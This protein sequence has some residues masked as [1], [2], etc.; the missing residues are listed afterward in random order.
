M[1]NLILVD[2][3]GFLF[4]SFFAL[5]PLS[6]SK[7]QPSGA[8]SGFVQL[9]NQLFNE[10]PQESIIFALEG[11][12]ENFRKNIDPN[13]KA[14][15]AAT[16]P[17]LAA[18]VPVAI[19]WIEKM[20]LQS[21]SYDGFEA[22]DIIATLATKAALRGISVRII[23]HDKDLNQLICSE[24]SSKRSEAVIESSIE[25]NA[26]SGENNKKGEIFL[27]DPKNKKEIREKEVFEKYA[28]SPAQFIDYQ[29]IIGDTSDN[30]AGVKGI[31]PKGASALL[32]EFGSLDKIYENLEKISNARI[33]NLLQTSKEAAFLSRELVR[34]RR[35][36]PL[37]L[38]LEKSKM[39]N[40]NPL[41][42]IKDELENYELNSILKK[43]GASKSNVNSDS[44][45][46]DSIESS[47][48]LN[49]D[50]SQ[51]SKENAENKINNK[52]DSIE[53]YSHNEKDKFSFSSILVEND[54]HLAE[55]E[56]K[57]T[58]DSIISFDTETTALDTKSAKIVGFSFS[59]DG[60]VGYYAPLSH[61]YLGAPKQISKQ[62]ASEFIKKL[63][64]AKLIIAHNWKFDLEI[65][66][67]N[68]EFTPK[69]LENLA[70]SMILAWLL[71][72]SGKHSLDFLM[73]KFFFHKMIKFSEIVKK[74]ENF[75][76][77]AVEQGAIYAS[78]D[79][80]AAWVLYDF[81]KEKL[82]NESELLELAKSVEMPF[83][84]VLAQM[85]ANGIKVDRAYLNAL[86]SEYSEI[87]NTLSSEI[88][89][90]CGS[91]FN[92]N[93]PKQLSDMLFGTLGLKGKK[94]TKSGFASTN[95]TALNALKDEH[96]SISKI[97]QYR[98][99]SKLQSTYVK[100]LLEYSAKSA[101]SRVYAS[102]IH[103]GTE[104][105]RLSSD[106]PN[107]QNIP[108]RSEQGRRIRAAFIAE[109]NHA[110]I[111]LDY[112]QIELRLLAHFSGDS[113][114][115]ADFQSG[116][117][118]HSSTA[119]R[120]F[121]ESFI[122]AENSQKAHMRGIAKGI[123][124]GLIYGMGAR[125]LAE[126]LKIS[127]NEAKKYITEYFAQFPSVR[128]FLRSLETEILENGF[129]RT[130]L[131]RK[132]RLNFNGVAEYVKLGFLREGVN[133]VFQGSAA[134]I[135]K[136]AMNKIFIESEITAK[137]LAQ[138]HDELIFECEKDKA[139]E[140]SIKIAEIM[141]NVVQLKVPLK[142]GISIAQNWGELK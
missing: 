21:I 15:R 82:Q 45:K 79:A 73:E 11:K 39:P 23:S 133:A 100:P 92:L 75:S 49:A 55:L 132:R 34:L 124:F 112:S 127:N 142:V 74:D 3:F 80:A 61:N 1:K 137:L 17:D 53:S 57:I 48:N 88:F 101:K 134:D 65:L 52:S 5:P 117:D 113:A 71:E 122:N 7:G 44:I 33:K 26:S 20:G 85:E 96:P 36:L 102:F 109:E 64:S 76:D 140:Q 67:N 63:F 99:I 43:I 139:K 24:V 72:S 66:R 59:F 118:I 108:I 77:I 95:E 25:S 141:E 104:T 42:K 93:S 47:L 116:A 29:S 14:N 9:I 136:L 121:G 129:S 60:K 27:Y 22:D 123:N 38:D 89:A 78:E 130:L 91:S 62:A 30:V 119:Q 90:L 87:L 120:L 105:G 54:S 131:G 94:M 28:V 84:A 37:E 107:L 41:L 8:I 86:E 97:L 12:G 111:S 40:F 115:I 4:R 51:S 56:S 106:H 18:Q 125:K 68:F 114:M 58:A 35:D 32:G 103:T 98:E 138:V 83:V 2:T 31:G 81:L 6:N 50:F 110:L 10:Y 19:S 128:D 46:L 13:Y 16:P 69:S 70:D 135:I 126:D